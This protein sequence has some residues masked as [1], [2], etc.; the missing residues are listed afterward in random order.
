MILNVTMPPDFIGDVDK[1][2]LDHEF[3][4]GVTST[5]YANRVMPCPVE[6][7]KGGAVGSGSRT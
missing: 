6:E 1:T 7:S 2:Q 3:L 5:H 4:H